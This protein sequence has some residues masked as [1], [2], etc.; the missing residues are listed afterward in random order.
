MN[1][2]SAEMWTEY[3]KFEIGFVESMRRRWDVLG[4]NSGRKG[5]GKEKAQGQV[6]EGMDVE[7]MQTEADGEGD[8]AELARREIMKGAIV[9]SVMSN[10][11]KGALLS[12]VFSC[13]YLIEFRQPYPRQNY[14]H[15]FM[16]CCHHTPQRRPSE[17]YS[18]NTFSSSFNKHSPMTQLRCG[19]LLRESSQLT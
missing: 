8:E 3:V 17:N 11:A 7:Q 1:A 19:S 13:S 10:A 9:K 16:H 15:L 2:E 4:I 6:I 18:C 12:S 5:K 14:S